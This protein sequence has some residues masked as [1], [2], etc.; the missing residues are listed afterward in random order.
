MQGPRENSTSR[1]G[2]RSKTFHGFLDSRPKPISA[3]GSRRALPGLIPSTRPHPFDAG[4]EVTAGWSG[5]PT[6]TLSRQPEALRHDLRHVLK[7]LSPQGPRLG[8]RLRCQGISLVATPESLPFSQSSWCPRDRKLTSLDP[9]G[10]HLLACQKQVSLSRPADQIVRPEITRRPL[11]G[12]STP[13]PPRTLDL[14]HR[15]AGIQDTLGHAQSDR[16]GN[17]TLGITIPQRTARGHQPHHVR[18]H[19]SA[20]PDNDRHVSQLAPLRMNEDCH[21]PHL[22]TVGQLQSPTVR[23]E[24][25]DGRTPQTQELTVSDLEAIN[26]FGHDPHRKTTR[27]EATIDDLAASRPNR[28]NRVRQSTRGW[29]RP[30]TGTSSK[31]NAFQSQL[32]LGVKKRRLERSTVIV[33]Q[34]DHRT[35]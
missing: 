26:P 14:Q 30:A 32:A 16:P 35:T 27:R 23:T 24:P 6:G 22:D 34:T 12:R 13:R 1:Y 18:R 5:P 33:F 19:K 17:P 4:T 25:V 15:V 20:L 2:G 8:T 29:T 7:S 10:D 9:H 28:E 11:D 31:H 21:M 3:A